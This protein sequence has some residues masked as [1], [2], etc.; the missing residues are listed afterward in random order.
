VKVGLISNSRPMKL[1]TLHD[2]LI[3]KL[4][5]LYDIE[6]QLEKTLPKLARHV[7]NEKFRK[8]LSTHAREVKDEKKTLEKIFRSLGAKRGRIASDGFRGMIAD[9]E[10]ILKQDTTDE[11]RDAAL[12]GAVQAMEHYEMAAYGTA[13][14]WAEQMDHKDVARLLKKSTKEEERA[15]KKLSKIAERIVN[16][17]VTQHDARQEQ[18]VR[19]AQTRRD[20]GL[21]A[22]LM[23][24]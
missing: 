19:R 7:H 14:A 4:H 11:A 22:G 15:D 9:A 2:L 3:L 16:K 20:A 18:Q 23:G 5:V 17:E 6:N 13:R 8:L 10:W 21:T 24:A 12:I 1:N